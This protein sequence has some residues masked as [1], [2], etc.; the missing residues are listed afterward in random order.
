MCLP[1]LLQCKSQSINNS[2]HS[3]CTMYSMNHFPKQASTLDQCWCY[4]YVTVGL[5]E[6]NN[7]SVWCFSAHYVKVTWHCGATFLYIFLSVTPQNLFTFICFSVLTL[8]LCSRHLQ[9]SYTKNEHVSNIFAYSCILNF[10]V[11]CIRQ[12]KYVNNT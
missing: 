4:L 8:N 2:V 9:C 1:L 11:Q 6:Q 10:S 7:P 3:Y 12:K 5:L